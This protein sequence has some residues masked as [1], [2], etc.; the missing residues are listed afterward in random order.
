MGY[1][2]PGICNIEEK[3]DAYKAVKKEFRNIGLEEKGV[4]LI[5]VC[6]QYINDETWYPI[7]REAKSY[8][9]EDKQHLDAGEF[10]LPMVTPQDLKAGEMYLGIDDVV[11]PGSY[12]QELLVGIEVTKPIK[13]K[14]FAEGLTKLKKVSENQGFQVDKERFKIH[15]F[16]FPKNRKNLK[17]LVKD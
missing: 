11:E 15:A 12:H 3:E 5:G 4:K 6:V 2:I 10:F 7:T 8:Y 16:V 13:N 9:P 14:E 1:K 17:E